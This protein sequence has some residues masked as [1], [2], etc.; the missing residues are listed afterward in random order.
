[1]KPETRKTMTAFADAAIADKGE[2]EEVK[3][4]FDPKHTRGD[5]QLT[6]GEACRLAG[7]VS[8]TLYR[9]ERQGHLHPARITKSRVRWS[10]AELE[11][12]LCMA[13]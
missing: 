1:M 11:D 7:V 8:K 10:R 3:A 9:W 4:L 12:F 6:T 13:G 5:R 2:R